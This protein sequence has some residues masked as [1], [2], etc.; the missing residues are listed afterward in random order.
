MVGS[1][2]TG[3]SG[4]STQQSALDNESHNIANVNTIGYKSSRISF[5]DQMYQDAIGKGSKVLDAEKVFSQGNMKS[6]GVSYDVALE[7]SGF[8]AVKYPNAT[9]SSEEFYTRAGNFRMGDSGTLQDANSYDVIGWGISPLDPEQDV[10]TTNGNILNFTNDYSKIAANQIIQKDGM[11][12][13]ITG[14]FTDYQSTATSDDDSVMSGLGYKTMSSKINDVEALIT[15]YQSK[16][17]EYANDPEANSSPSIAQKSSVTLPGA[18]ISNL[19]D[20][21]DQ[22]SVY[23][24]GKKIS[25]NYIETTATTY[26]I[27]ATVDH[28]G[29][30]VTD[31]TDDD[32]LASK[33]MT[34]RALADEIS[35]TTGLTAYMADTSFDKTE[36]DITTVA[37][38]FETD[39]ILVIEAL[40]PGEEFILGDSSEYIASSKTVIPGTNSI[41]TASVEGAGF[42]AVES[43]REALIKAGSGYQ[44]DVWSSTDLPAAAGTF[45]LTDPDNSTMQYSVTAGGT[46]VDDYVAAINAD[47]D[48]SEFVTAFNYN[49]N[50]VIETKSTNPG[51]TFVGSIAESGTTYN[52][53]TEMSVNSG[54]DA[55]FLEMVNKLN[56]TAAK[57][58]LQLR[59]DNLGISD[60][61]FGEFNVDSTGLITMTQDGAEFAVGQL[62]IAMFNNERGLTSEGNNLM[63]KTN[64][65][66]EAIYNENN[67]KAAAVASQT[68][69]LSTADL[70]ESLVNLMVFQRAFEANSKS[71]TT[72]DQIL[73]TLI[74]LKK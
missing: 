31:T 9:G 45:T 70:S 54:A 48:I 39:P 2:W 23:I 1:L 68:L 12:E 7:G 71:I 28:N 10:T 41:V 53:N 27:T 57:D 30:G 33:I 40:V 24:D 26:G 35:E 36:G 52:K 67:D 61:A 49:G 60:S 18:A 15:D 13:T 66:G 51:G 63:G 4:L 17:A 44:R 5:A 64:D 37:A 50:L 38:A 69:E 16:L 8:F 3:I 58:S 42:G 43:A 56:Q 20:E 11:I 19:T 74:Q 14:K 34:Y 22:V 21:S 6:T 55:E 65:S 46:T 73:T 29:D 59:L 25:V 62:S 47:A 32:I 72:S